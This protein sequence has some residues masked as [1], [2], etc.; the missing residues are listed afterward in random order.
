MNNISRNHHY[1]PQSY[2]RGFLDL[3]LKKE[4]LH[5]IDK[6]ERRHFVTSPRNVGSQR[7]FN[8]I[9]I[10]GRPI[11]DAEKQLLAL[12]DGKAA[13][14]LKDI[15]ENATLPK[16]TDM[17]TLVYFVAL[18]AVHN[19]QIRNSLANA[20]TKK[21]KKEM[22]LLVS[23]R[24]RYE[25]Q[26]QQLFEEGKEMLEYE[27]AKR[28]VEEDHFH[29][30]YGHGHH[31]KYELDTTHNTVYPILSQKQWSLLI[32]EEDTS[33]FVCSDRPVALVC[34]D[35]N[36][37][38]NPYHPYARPGLGMRNTELT[39][40]LNRRMALVAAFE[41]GF[42]V[43]TLNEYDIAV[44]NARTIDSAEKQIYCSNLDF[45]F[46]DN[47]EVKSGGDLVD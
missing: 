40:P 42:D 23:S 6:I 10:P 29:I 47:G 19:P 7:D 26:V 15:A 4:Q 11:D 45:K 41:N 14:V 13:K 46:L 3:S 9:E 30:K 35:A 20:E 1:I 28:F 5:V 36:P 34:T 18:I 17:V 39:V 27:V 21:I 22:R 2:L 33:N 24:E 38:D 8:R 32:A 44:L 12:I 43:A 37:P 31:L 25:S 16:D